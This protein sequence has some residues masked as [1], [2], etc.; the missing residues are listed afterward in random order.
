MVGECIVV[1]KNTSHVFTCDQGW[2]FSILIAPTSSLYRILS[3]KMQGQNYYVVES[4][5][6]R[7]YDN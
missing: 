2:H 3:Q 4:S 5:Q 7:E 1:N 6:L